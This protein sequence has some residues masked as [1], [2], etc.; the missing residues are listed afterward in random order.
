MSYTCPTCSGTGLVAGS[1][2]PRCLGHKTLLEDSQGLTVAWGSVD[3]GKLTSVRGTSPTVSTE[4]VTGLNSPFKSFTNNA[5]TVTHCGM[6]RQL[7]AG[8]LTPGK[9]DISWKGKNALTNDMVGHEKALVITHTQNAIVMS[10]RAILLSYDLNAA[11]GEMIEG[12]ASFQ[13]TEV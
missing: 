1:T 3:L 13:L 4:D 5:S 6:V 10:K 7:I 11:V 8:D 9:I 2:C 12:S